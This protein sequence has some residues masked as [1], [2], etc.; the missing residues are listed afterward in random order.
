M[1]ALSALYRE[2]IQTLRTRTDAILADTGF[3]S[4][5]IFAGALHYQFLDDMSYPFKVNPHFKTWLPIVDNPNCWLVIR[6]GALPEVLYY[7]PVDYW[8][9]VAGEPEGDW[10]EHCVVRVL[11][12]PDEA[13]DF[14]RNLGKTAFLG[15]WDSRF[16][17]WLPG[18]A[19]NPEE[20]VARLNWVRAVKTGYEQD[21]IRLA[22]ERAA[23]GHVAARNAFHAGL[24]TLEIHLEY[25][26]A[27][28]HMEH[29]LPYGNI[30]ALNQDAAVLHYHECTARRHAPEDL[31]AFLIDGG[32]SVNGYAADITRTY[33]YRDG[34]FKDLI[35]AMDAMQRDLIGT[36]KAGTVYTDYH[37]DAHLRIARILQDFDIVRL[38]PEACLE[39]NVCNTFFAHGL[40]H[41]LGLQVHD[42]GGHQAAYEGGR[43]PPPGQH[44]FLRLT[45]RL[46]AG[47]VFTIEPG[48]YF[49]PSLLN[50]LRHGEH[51]GAVNWD[52]VEAFLPCG[53]IR[54]EDNI[55]VKDEGIENFTRDAFRALG[56]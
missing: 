23:R 26:K 27:T 5:A 11:R 48:L 33:A 29:E 34:E 45:R 47:Q 19:Q 1:T 55:L 10:V 36:I 53:G 4:L 56:V 24:S 7:Q 14:L 25:L 54:I 52:K 18:A 37:V 17:D 6:R 22:N 30:I 15:E 9:K 32:A 13:K 12:K 51:A 8:H 40:G 50:E 3:D 49:I 41:F 35:A 31:H 28:G 20:L 38:S 16:G 21:C 42:V 2:H 43:N 46:E 44:P 39:T